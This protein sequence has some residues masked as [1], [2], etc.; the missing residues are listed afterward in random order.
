MNRTFVL[1]LL[2]GLGDR[3]YA[4]LGGKTPLQ[5]AETPF[6]DELAGMGCNGLFHASFQGQALPSEN[7]HFAM[8]GYKPDDFPG[9]GA[10]EALGAGIDLAMND[11]AVLA[12]LVQ[13]AEEDGCLK[14]V[15]EKVKADKSYF[16][17]AFKRIASFSSD[18]VELELIPYKGSFAII[19]L[20][21][22]VSP[23][24]TDS[25]PIVEGRFLLEVFPWKEYS[26]HEPSI[27]TAKIMNQY[28]AWAWKTLSRNVQSDPDAD[29]SAAVLNGLITQRAGQ[30][31]KVIPFHEKFG[32][33]GASISSGAI[34]AGLCSYLGIKHIKGHEDDDPGE[35]I[36]H[37]I[38][39]AHGL[40]DTHNFIHVH[41]KAP[42]EAGHAKDPLLKRQAIE[43]LDKGLA[44]SLPQLLKRKDIVLAVTADHST[45]CRGV[46]VHSGEPVPLCILGPGVRKDYVK[47]FDEVSAGAGGLG[48]VR[49]PELMPMVLNYLDRGKL[50]GLMDTPVD[51]PYW[52][53]RS[54][55]LRVD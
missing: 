53:G 46:M 52:P 31:K 30:L 51:Q 32:L 24:I 54:K 33:N 47:K 3:S 5:A 6:L 19:K 29:S 49:G 34:Y 4:E 36:R 50:V 2:D 43:Q 55:P 42:D 14:F 21:G 39:Q 38:H 28:L 1:I 20:T 23:F 18:V 35:E 45:P 13:V 48:F 11:V 27:R 9:R 41:S 15:R 22:V 40:L 7:A 16:Q 44:A 26:S 37:R 8:F 25:N 17:Q 12:N 10:L